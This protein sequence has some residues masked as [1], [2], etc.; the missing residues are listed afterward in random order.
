MQRNSA[1]YYREKTVK[2]EA[3][4]S[5]YTGTAEK[6]SMCEKGMPGSA[7]RASCYVA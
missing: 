5:G 4:G 3:G 1:G 6:N 2:E 7:A